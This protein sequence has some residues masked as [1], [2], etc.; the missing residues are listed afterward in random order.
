LRVSICR[1][2]VPPVPPS[3]LEIADAVH[4]LMASLAAID[5]RFGRWQTRDH[6]YRDRRV[7]GLDDCARYLREAEIEWDGGSPPAGLPSHRATFFNGRP[8][9]DASHLAIVFGGRGFGLRLQARIGAFERNRE[10][11]STLAIFEACLRAFAPDWGFLGT[12]RTPDPRWDQGVR[13]EVGWLTYLSREMNDAALGGHA[14]TPGQVLRPSVSLPAEVLPLEDRGWIISV[15]PTAVPEDRALQETYLAT[16]REQLGPRVRQE[17]VGRVLSP[18][19]E[20]IAS[21]DEPESRWARWAGVHDLGGTGGVDIATLARAVLPFISESPFS[22]SLPTTPAPR[23]PSEPSVT[24]T[25]LALELPI[26]RSALPFA[27]QAGS[28]PDLSD[29]DP[30]ATARLSS[31]PIPRELLPGA[32]PSSSVI[33]GLTLDEYAALCAALAARPADVEALFA[34]RG[35]ADRARRRVVDS[36]WQTYLASDAEA[37]ARWQELYR[38]HAGASR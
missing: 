33:E 19:P 4:R 28:P 15:S 13:P 35:L 11:Q 23:A 18:A 32:A 1:R 16:V 30:A 9:D 37:Y 10:R 27:P 2:R 8:A 25:A 22:P 17:G 14:T 38:R 5:P 12:A 31:L 21:V 20:A 7:I 24:G 3:I 29:A 36:A 6:G 34:A 26:P